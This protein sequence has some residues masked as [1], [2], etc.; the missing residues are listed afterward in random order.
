MLWSSSGHQRRWLLPAAALLAVVSIWA[1]SGSSAPAETLQEKYDATQGKLDHVRDSERSLSAT[2]A[3]Q[4]AAI[5][6]MLGEVSL[7][8][9]RQA[10]IEAELAAKQAELERASAKL[11]AEKERLARIRA[12]LKRAL[13]VLRERL[14]AIYEAG[15]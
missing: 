6:S 5:D 1:A 12:R 7:L 10:A 15:S 8:R 3:E 4:N 2:I 11:E 9:R 13:S 14:V